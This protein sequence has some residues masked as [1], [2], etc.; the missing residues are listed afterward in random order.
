MIKISPS[1]LACDF[2]RMGEEIARVDKFSD[3]LHVDVMDGIFV[4]NIS[5]GMPVIKSIRKVTDIV[6]DVHLMIERPERYIDEFAKLGSD[7]I[8]IHYES[9][10]DP[11]A[12]LK[13]IREKG[14]KAGISIKPGTDVSVLFPLL[15]LCDLVL[16]MTVEPGF[17]GQKFM[18]DMM[19]KVSVLR[20]IVE[21]EN[22]NIE[23]EVDGGINAETAAIVA[24]AGANVLVAGA[25]VFAAEDAQ[26]AIS[27]MREAAEKAYKY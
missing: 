13:M 24:N 8:T 18:H 25:S 10:K 4:P 11:A 7:I 1:I 2:A 6:F 27:D 15:P 22:Y 16:V 5:F 26:K 12:V 19:D 21:K 14:K 23:I 20:N 9:T 3:Y 17:G